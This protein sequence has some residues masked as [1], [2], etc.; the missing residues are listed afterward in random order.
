M[1]TRLKLIEKIIVYGEN[2]LKKEEI[3]KID[4]GAHRSA[5]DV[6]LVSQLKLGPIIAT[7]QVKSSNGQIELRPIIRVKIKIGEQEVTDKFSV[8]NRT[9]MKFPILIGKT[10]LKKIKAVIQTYEE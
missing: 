6:S 10:L 4:T 7:K 1:E 8:T 9:N 2:D 3:A 5:I